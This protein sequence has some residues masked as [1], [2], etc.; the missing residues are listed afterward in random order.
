M[1][2]NIFSLFSYRSKRDV[3]YFEC[4]LS[5]KEDIHE[6]LKDLKSGGVDILV[7]AAGIY[8]IILDNSIH[9][10]TDP[11]I[12]QSI[13][14]FLI[15]SFIYPSIY[16]LIHP[17]IQSFIYPSINHSIRPFIDPSI[18]PAIH[19]SNHSFIFLQVDYQSTRLKICLMSFGMKI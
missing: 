15:D 8:S 18:H 10:L 11:S 9:P 13:H 5:N 14:P 12:H 2:C 1:L 16:P 3:K 19:S 4:D 7:N 17:F 6:A